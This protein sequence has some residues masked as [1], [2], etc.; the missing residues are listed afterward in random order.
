M[1]REHGGTRLLEYVDELP[2]DMLSNRVSRDGS[3]DCVLFTSMTLSEF[4]EK[5]RELEA[6]GAGNYTV[7]I[8]DDDSLY[9]KK[10]L[11]VERCSSQTIRIVAVLCV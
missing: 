10:V 9:Y 1:C 7:E 11:E 2:L 3:S 5:L 8:D 6:M 4:I